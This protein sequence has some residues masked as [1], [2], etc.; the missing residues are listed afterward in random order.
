MPIFYN[1]E[2]LIN[3]FLL[4]QLCSNK[5]TI[6][7][8]S[9]QIKLIFD[10]LSINLLQNPYRNE[11]KIYFTTDFTFIID[12]LFNVYLSENHSSRL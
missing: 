5:K 7:G 3:S 11:T 6:N 1:C 10:P 12:F 9:H 2:I 4:F 8:F